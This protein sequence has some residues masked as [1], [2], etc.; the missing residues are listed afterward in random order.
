MFLLYTCNVSGLKAKDK[1]VENR[2]LSTHPARSFSDM[3]KLKHRALWT[4][5]CQSHLITR[6]PVEALITTL[7]KMH[8]H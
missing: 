8:Q 2:R 4:N 5:C 6:I 7:I 1:A 3:E